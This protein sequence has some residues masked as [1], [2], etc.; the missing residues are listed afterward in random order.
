MWCNFTD[1]F[2][3]F[4]LGF[5]FSTRNLSD[6]GRNRSKKGMVA[7]GAIPPIIRIPCQPILGSSCA[8]RMPPNAEPMVKPQNIK[9]TRLERRRVGLYSEV[10]VIA[11]GIA[12]PKPRPVTKRQKISEFKSVANAE[13]RLARPKTKMEP[14][15]IVLRPNLSESIQTP[16]HRP[17]NQINPHQIMVPDWSLL[18]PIQLL[19]RVQ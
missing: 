8:D 2:I 11:F 5:I 10:K 3:N 16:M 18:M 1:N 14:I 19:T 9:V 7:S 17:S 4:F 12:P 6:S 15:K 13:M